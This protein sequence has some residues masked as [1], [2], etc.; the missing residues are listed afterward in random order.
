MHYYVTYRYTWQNWALMHQPFQ[1][2][3]DQI[4]TFS[5][6][7]YFR[8]IALLVIF[9]QY[10]NKFDLPLPGY[11]RTRGFHLFRYPFF[12]SFPVSIGYFVI[13]LYRSARGVS[14]TIETYF[15]P[16]V[17]IKRTYNGMSIVSP[18]PFTLPSTW[19]LRWQAQSWSVVQALL[20]HQIGETFTPGKGGIM[21]LTR[22][23]SA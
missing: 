4:L 16:L 23:P 13:G 11:N 9:S 1:W 15:V 6:Y 14:G 18:R 7:L 21:I 5:I 12:R 3:F 8:T 20:F 22:K 10:L 2:W 19:V 17:G